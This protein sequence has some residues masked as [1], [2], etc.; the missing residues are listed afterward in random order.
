MPCAVI[1]V[2]VQTYHED[3]DVYRPE[4]FK[5]DSEMRNQLMYHSGV[6]VHEKWSE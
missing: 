2:K 1:I 4:V 3:N 5:E 6:R